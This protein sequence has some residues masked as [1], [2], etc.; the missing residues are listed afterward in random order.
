[1]PSL[2]LALGASTPPF[3]D[4][5]ADEHAAK[6]IAIRMRGASEQRKLANFDTM[7]YLLVWSKRTI[8]IPCD[9]RAIMPSERPPS[10]S[11]LG[12]KPSPVFFPFL[13]VLDTRFR[14][15]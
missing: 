11:P 15:L 3:D 5:E 12:S 10:S 7:T 6:M 13:S 9:K 14:V 1:M 2:K 8:N 4:G